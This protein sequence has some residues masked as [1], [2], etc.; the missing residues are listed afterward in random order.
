MLWYKKSKIKAP[1]NLVLKNKLRNKKVLPKLLKGSFSLMRSSL[2]RR[3]RNFILKKMLLGKKFV[4]STR[5]KHLIQK[6]TQRKLSFKGKL[7][8][9]FS[10]MKLKKKKLK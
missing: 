8:T 10:G 2:R 6:K 9:K 1:Y 3:S 4:E 5:T 7:T